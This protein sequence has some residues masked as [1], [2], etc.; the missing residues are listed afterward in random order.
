MGWIH[1][2]E[3]ILD[4]V[5]KIED[6]KPDDAVGRTKV[7][8]DGVSLRWVDHV[9]NQLVLMVFAADPEEGGGEGQEKGDK[10]G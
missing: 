10:G 9:I 2:V 4:I 8:P 5:V 7:A 3:L 6:G 1:P